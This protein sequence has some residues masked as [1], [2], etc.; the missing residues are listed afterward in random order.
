[1]S[2]YM[3]PLLSNYL[4]DLNVVKLNFDFV[5]EWLYSL[6]PDWL[7]STFQP[8][9]GFYDDIGSQIKIRGM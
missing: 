8:E 6:S 1:M 9:L 3:S 2:S 4:Q 7:S 5:Y